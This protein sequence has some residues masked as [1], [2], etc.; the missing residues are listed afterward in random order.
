M[1]PL[2]GFWFVSCGYD[3]GTFRDLSNGNR[4]E[5]ANDSQNPATGLSTLALQNTPTV[6]YDVTNG[7][8][9]LIVQFVARDDDGI[10][11]SAN[12]FDV[13]LLIDGKP[14]DSESLLEQDSVELES[15]VF[16]TM[17]LDASFSMLQHEPP[18]FS[19]ML[20]AAK[21]SVDSL[22]ELW[23]NRPGE[24][25]FELMWFEEML[26]R[27]VGVWNSTDILGIPEPSA[28]TATKL[29]GAVEFMAQHHDQRVPNWIGR[30]RARQ[31]RDGG[32]YRWRR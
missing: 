23:S 7:K 26:Y 25:R 8:T 3:A 18:A 21:N 24:V 28:G 20:R 27:Q 12:Q 9:T 17:V 31:P 5:P 13:D 15:N 22:L 2:F 30:Q 4:F 14:L 10:P 19:P 16:Y 11:L 1:L 29:Y 32:V 6:R